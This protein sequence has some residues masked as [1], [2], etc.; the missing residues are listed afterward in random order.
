MILALICWHSLLS[1]SFPCSPIYLFIFINFFFFF[2][3]LATPLAICISWA[4][5]HN[6]ATVATFAPAV[7]ML[8][9]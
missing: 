1:K 2:F 5:V 4:W 6:P 7:T 9:P 3:F 8:D